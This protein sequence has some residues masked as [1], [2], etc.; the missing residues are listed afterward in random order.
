ME[1]A[2]DRGHE[3]TLFNRG[4]TGAELCPGVERLAGD[5]D[6]DL[7]ALTGRSFDVALDTSGYSPAQV[8]AT[9]LTGSIGHYGFVSSL[10]V[11]ADP[12]RPGL[13][14]TAAVLGLAEQDSEERRYGAQ[15]AL[16]ERAAEEILP[17][18]V[19]AVRSGL[20]VGP[21]DPTNRFTY[22]VSRLARG[23]EVL[24]PKPRDQPVQFI[25]ARDLANWML[26]KAEQGTA[27]TFNV[28]GPARPL[29]LGGLLEAIQAEVGESAKLEWVD[30][31][32]LLDAGVESWSELPLW[33]AP[34]VNP[35]YAGFL[36]FDITR[37][38]ASG[39]RVRPLAET[40][41]DTLAWAETGGGTRETFGG[42]PPA[43]L[44]PA[45]E[46]EVLARWTA[47]VARLSGG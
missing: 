17:G 43:G 46:Q 45:K 41:H 38:L 30:E 39:L 37:A 7:A 3:V 25:D 6:G 11:Y 31:Q 47:R 16:S 8:A 27:G 18:R 1:A 33:I 34:G 21:Y 22:W 28:T 9:A 4:R 32:F 15:K 29:S 36:S 42:F 26:D 12:S 10:S 20:I 14:E 44:D 35:E 40:V 13:D 23:G 24:A 19:L 5:R 2:L